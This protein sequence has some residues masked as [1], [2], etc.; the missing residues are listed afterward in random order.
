M[1]TICPGLVANTAEKKRRKK[2]RHAFID[3][4]AIVSS[5]LGVNVSKGL[6]TRYCAW[7]PIARLDRVNDEKKKV[8]RAWG[9][10]L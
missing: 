9:G 6:Y 5:L 4:R 8:Q 3:D 1:T 2:V 10:F 7:R